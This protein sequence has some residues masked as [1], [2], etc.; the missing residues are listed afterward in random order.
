MD[1]EVLECE[2]VIADVGFL[3]LGLLHNV[4]RKDAVSLACWQQKEGE[5][6]LGRQ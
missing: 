5:Q 2:S 1:S 4:V 3:M 6:P